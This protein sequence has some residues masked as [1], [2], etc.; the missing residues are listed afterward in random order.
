MISAVAAGL[1][2]AAAD[3]FVVM[4]R[5]RK[6]TRMTKKEVKDENKNSEGDPL[7]KSQRRSR[8][9]AMSR[10]RMIASVATAD[11]VIVNP[12]HV[13]VALRYEPGKSR[14][15]PGRQG[16]RAHRHPHPRRSGGRER[17]HGQGHPARPGA[18]RRLRDRP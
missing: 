17:A 7:I 12:T 9:L 8:Q 3:V 14:P 4:K 13:A 18:A 15:A 6:Q 11:V 2:L 16:L 10:N 5:N 1:V